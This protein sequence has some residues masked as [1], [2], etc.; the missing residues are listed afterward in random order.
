VVAPLGESQARC[1]ALALGL[2]DAEEKTRRTE[3]LLGRPKSRA[4]LVSVECYF[5]QPDVI[6][7]LLVVAVQLKRDID[8]FLVPLGLRRVVGVKG[9]VAV[10]NTKV[11]VVHLIAHALEGPN[12][13]NPGLRREVIAWNRRE[14][15]QFVKRIPDIPPPTLVKVALRSKSL[16]RSPERLVGVELQ[17][18]PSVPVIDVE[19]QI[20][21]KM[22]YAVPASHRIPIKLIGIGV[23]SRHRELG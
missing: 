18:L 5:I 14:P 23:R 1:T 11:D 3:E 16:S 7:L 15:P 22:A 12:Q 8:F 19:P 4:G 21:S 13:V 17:R 6:R 20:V 9:V 2:G 10:G